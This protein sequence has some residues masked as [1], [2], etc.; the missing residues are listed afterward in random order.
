M[1]NPVELG[2]KILS[3][4]IFD[5]R[6]INLS[7]V[8][9]AI[10][11]LDGEDLSPERYEMDCENLRQK[12]LITQNTRFARLMTRGIIVPVY[13]AKRFSQS[14]LEQLYKRH[15]N[16]IRYTNIYPIIFDTTNMMIISKEAAQN[17]NLLIYPLLEELFKQGEME[18][19]SIFNETTGE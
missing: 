9:S 13:C 6:W 12:L 5:K 8:H 7:R 14:V 16:N 4:G 10:F 19:R 17:D 1:N 15:R 11:V 3:S 18:A 2:S